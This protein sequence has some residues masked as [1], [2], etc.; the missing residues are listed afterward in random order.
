MK[1][2]RI[3]DCY[4]LL[5]PMPIIKTAQEFKKMKI[6]ETLEVLSTDEGIKSDMP[7]WCKATGNE[8]LGIE[9]EDGEYKVYVKK[10]REI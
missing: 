6:G 5:C 4:G 2:D 7:A 9:E 3:L 1:A 10:S 8:F